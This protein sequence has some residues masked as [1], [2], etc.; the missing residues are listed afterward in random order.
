M[1]ENFPATAD[2]KVNADFTEATTE[3]AKGTRSGCG[4]ILEALCGRR[5]AKV[6][7]DAQRAAAQAAVDDQ[8]IRAGLARH[9]NEQVVYLTDA[10]TCARFLA[11]SRDQRRVENLSACLEEAV[12]AIDEDPTFSLPGKDIDLDFLDDWQDKAERTNSD[13][14]RTLWG[15]ILKGELQQPGK[16]P[17]RIL[18]IL[19]NLTM[20]EAELFTKVARYA[21]G[22]VI[23]LPEDEGP[24]LLGNS[25]LVCDS[26]LFS[27]SL[28]VSKRFQYDGETNINLSAADCAL[29]LHFSK[30]LS[31]EIN[32]LSGYSLNKAGIALLQLPDIE[33]LT[34]EHL[35]K[36]FLT[37]KKNIRELIQITA[38]PWG[39]D[40]HQTLDPNILLCH[41]PDLG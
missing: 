15:R 25:S 6:R 10:A 36:I 24:K 11:C 31:G 20:E 29:A 16:Y 33:E 27:S 5:L 40:S 8:L 35:E 18:G 2:V 32:T 9:E 12:K 17:R 34:E 41:Y 14:M 19:R 37:V 1:P 26:G 38:H 13:Y 39:D 28:S 21:V 30:P 3:L 23:V 7:A 22:G 4:M